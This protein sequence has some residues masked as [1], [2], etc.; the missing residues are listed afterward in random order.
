[1]TAPA[2]DPTPPADEHSEPDSPAAR[3]SPVH[4]A[5][6]IVSD[7]VSG[8]NVR[9]NDN[10]FQAKFIAWSVLFF[11]VAGGLLA[12]FNRQWELPW[13]GGALIGILPGLIFGVFASGIYLM[14]YRALQHLRGKHD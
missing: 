1:M 6:N 14:I 8:V 11:V 5:Y 9:W 3:L 12:A 4:E 7:T 10:W 2:S 13:Y